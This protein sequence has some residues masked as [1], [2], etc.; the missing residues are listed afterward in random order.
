MSSFNL[1]VKV[2]RASLSSITSNFIPSLTSEKYK[3]Q[4]GKIA[5]FGGS[6]LYT[7]AP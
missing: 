6:D 3:G 7:G 1:A 4:A 5:V 2:R